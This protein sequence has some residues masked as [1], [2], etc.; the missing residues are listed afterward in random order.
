MAK[1]E[2]QEIMADIMK[3][4]QKKASDA[5]QDRARPRSMRTAIRRAKLKEARVVGELE[6]AKWEKA[7]AA[8]LA[9]GPVSAP[10]DTSAGPPKGPK[11][12]GEKRQGTLD[13]PSFETHTAELKDVEAQK[14]ENARARPKPFVQAQSSP[15]KST[16]AP[17]AKPKTAPKTRSLVPPKNK[18]PRN[19]PFPPNTAI[20]PNR[21]RPGT[22]PVQGGTAKIMADLQAKASGSEP[23]KNTNARKTR[24]R[25]AAETSQKNPRPQRRTAAAATQRVSPPS[26]SAT[27]ATKP[28]PKPQLKIPS[29]PAPA[30]S[31][32]PSRY[33][34]RQGGPPAAPRRGGKTG[35]I[36]GGL[37]VAGGIAQTWFNES[38]RKKELE[39]INEDAH[40]F[41]YRTAPGPL[42]RK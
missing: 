5:P 12:I 35:I 40:P 22:A 36:I 41:R 1:K 19:G 3:E 17:A 33:L 9:S 30:L 15:Q 38:Q 2:D 29:S 13:R 11:L 20:D 25:K 16:S 24:Q 42:R 28:A 8:K 31:V 18:I 37:V 34:G 6:R 14:A 32:D 23:K 27:R 10:V 7:V 21:V 39:K 4:M 26:P